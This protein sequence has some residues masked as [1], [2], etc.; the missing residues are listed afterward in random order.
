[1]DFLG[2]LF[3]QTPSESLRIGLEIRVSVCVCVHQTA[4]GNSANKEL[5][6]SHLCTAV[7]A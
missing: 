6:D 2:C 7:T 3:R 1:M 4:D 5:Q